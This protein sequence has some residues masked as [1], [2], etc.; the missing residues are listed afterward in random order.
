MVLGRQ[1]SYRVLIVTHLQARD[2]LTHTHTFCGFNGIRESAWPS[3][4]HASFAQ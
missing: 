3:Q 4:K 1:F 2:T